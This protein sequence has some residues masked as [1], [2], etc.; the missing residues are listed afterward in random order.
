M[1]NEQLILQFKTKSFRRIPNPYFMD[2]NGAAKGPEMYI[3]I[4]DVKD[5]PDDIP[6]RT[7][8]REQRLTTAVAKK[9][10]RSL[11]DTLSKN[12]Y[13]LN[14]GLL[15]SAE[16]VQYDNKN[17]IAK[18]KFTDLSVHG[19]V[20]GGHTY[21]IIKDIKDELD[22][23]EQ[24]VKI[25]ILAGIEDMFQ[26]LAAARNTSVQ[27]QDKSIAELYQKFNIIK[28]AIAHEPYLND[29]YFKENEPG[30]IDVA[31]I[32]AILNLFNLDRY[33]NGPRDTAI[34]S[35]NAKK[36]CIDSYI[37]YYDQYCETIDNPYV[38][39]SRIIPDIFALYEHLET[40][41]GK[42]YSEAV[43]N[44]QY[45]RTIGVSVKKEG[46]EPFRSKFMNQ[47][48]RY[49]TPNGFLYPI[50]GA[51]RA[52]IEEGEDGYYRWK[53]GNPIT[54]LDNIGPEL[55]T[56]VVDMSRELGNNPNATG[57]NK[58][59]WQNLYMTVLMSTIK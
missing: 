14:R 25:E 16:S 1:N 51:F 13:L 36:A 4:C 27:V 58:T 31:D 35:Y 8:P 40:N 47:E 23:G 43:K 41:I 42:Y 22:Y 19:D 21:K 15:L 29:V 18:V 17:D 32:V 9:I 11:Q 44:G 34:V 55:V 38:K 52:V 45:G 39:M 46:A 10:K 56:S 24:Y 12:F 20:D 6:M 3:L 37:K 50:M 54:R 2:A 59:I 7:N 28:T 33:P 48:I 5:V 26:E 53:C 49:A 57:K 30:R